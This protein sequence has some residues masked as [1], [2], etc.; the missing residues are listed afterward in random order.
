V[1][2]DAY[3]AEGLI[4]GGSPDQGGDAACVDATDLAVVGTD[5]NTRY[6][7]SSLRDQPGKCNAAPIQIR[8]VPL[9]SRVEFVFATPGDRT[10]EVNFKDLSR[11]TVVGSAVTD[12][13]SHG[14]IDYVIVSGRATGPGA[15]PPPAI[16]SVTYAPLR[17]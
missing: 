8:F 4:L 5:P 9:A 3:S 11:T 13:G 12:D 6:L 15:A 1:D 2:S 16:R 14:G 7:A 17:G 10:L